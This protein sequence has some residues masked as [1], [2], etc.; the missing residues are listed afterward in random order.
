MGAKND[1]RAFP[2]RLSDS[3]TTLWRFLTR[4]NRYSAFSCR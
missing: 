2:D 3:S 4:D 1:C